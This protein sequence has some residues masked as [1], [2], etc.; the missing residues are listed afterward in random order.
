[1][2][3]RILSA[4]LYAIGVMLFYIGAAKIVRHLGRTKS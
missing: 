3:G 1:M 4:T 2:V